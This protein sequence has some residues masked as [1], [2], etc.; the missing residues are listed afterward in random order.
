MLAIR[1]GTCD[2]LAISYI[3]VFRLGVKKCP[4]MLSN[5]KSP[6]IFFYSNINLNHITDIFF[7]LRND[8][9]SNRMK[10]GVFVGKIFIKIF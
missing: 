2:L 9:N 10:F 1:N 3:G 8:Y 7:D 4:R 5:L 6:K